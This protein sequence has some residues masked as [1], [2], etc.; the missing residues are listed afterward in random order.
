MSKFIS[1][2]VSYLWDHPLTV[3][4]VLLCLILYARVMMAG[5]RQG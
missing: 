3:I 2:M 1:L 5:P 4:G